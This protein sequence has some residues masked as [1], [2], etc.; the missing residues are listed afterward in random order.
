MRNYIQTFIFS[1]S[2]MTSLIVQGQQYQLNGD[3]VVTNRTTSNGGA[4]IDGE[5]RLLSE[6]ASDTLVQ[7]ILFVDENGRVRQ[8]TEEMLDA[9]KTFSYNQ[10]DDGGPCSFGL[11]PNPN[12]VWRNGLGKIFVNESMKGCHETPNVGIGTDEPNYML[13]VVGDSVLRLTAEMSNSVLLTG[14][15]KD[16]DDVLRFLADGKIFV[17][18]V[19]VRKVEDF[20]DYVFEPEYKLMTLSELQTYIQHERKLPGMPSASEVETNG[21]D[22]GEMNRLLLEKIEELT[23]YV[24]QLNERV[25]ELEGEARVNGKN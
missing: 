13:D 2:L 10:A 14:V 8:L 20:P 21:V 22:L 23:L 3:L 7:R 6:S 16:G 24:L 4:D 5:F 25:E 12:P 15:S 1:I 11:S 9:L 19:N 17:T 18:E